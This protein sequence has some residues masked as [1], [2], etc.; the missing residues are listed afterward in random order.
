[1]EI[2]ITERRTQLSFV[3]RSVIPP[4]PKP[5][6]LPHLTAAPGALPRLDV[7]RAL[8]QLGR[9]AG[10][11][12]EGPSNAAT[13]SLLSCHERRD[14]PLDVAHRLG[15][16]VCDPA[17]SLAGTLSAAVAGEEPAK[18]LEGEDEIGLRRG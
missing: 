12:D 16:A 11:N 2:G 13:V 3:M 14:T 8:L 7:S 17:R 18:G 9:A 5:H 1:M 4:R 15:D 6:R 10:T